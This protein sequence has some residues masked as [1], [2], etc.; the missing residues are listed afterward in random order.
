MKYSENDIYFMKIALEQAE[1]AFAKEEVPVG[2]LL[3]KENQIIAKA[4]NLCESMFDPT[5]HAEIFVIRE[6]CKIIGNWRLADATL[7]VTKE[8]CVMCAGA[9]I[10][11]RLKRLVYG[12]KDNKA[13]GVDS[14]FNI[15]NDRRLN[16]QVEVLSGVLEKECSDILKNFFKMRRK[17]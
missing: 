13:G 1:Q 16:H 8:P 9:M 10:N 14:L 4:Y 6:S 3:V 17:K 2:A 15:L 11:C 5:A 12:C 7:Y